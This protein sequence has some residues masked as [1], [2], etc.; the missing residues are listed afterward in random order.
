MSFLDKLKSSIQDNIKIA[1]DNIQNLPDTIKKKINT[2]VSKEN[3]G[4]GFDEAEE[5]VGEVPAEEA[6]EILKIKSINGNVTIKGVKGTKVLKGLGAILITAGDGSTIVSETDGTI[7]IA[8]PSEKPKVVAAAPYTVTVT[9]D[10][11]SV[12]GTGIKPVS[13]K[14]TV[15]IKGNGKGK[16][17]IK[18][19]FIKGV[20][21]IIIITGKDGT[22][23]VKIP[24][25]K[26]PDGKPILTGAISVIG[27]DGNVITT[28]TDG[29]VTTTDPDGIITK[30]GP[31]GTVTATDEYGVTTTTPPS[32]SDQISRSVSVTFDKV[33][34]IAGPWL[35]AIFSIF[36]A[37]T[38]ANDMIIYPR[39][40]RII[41]FIFTIIIINFNSVGA[42]AIP[43]YYIVKALYRQ[44]MNKTYGT[45]HK[46][47]PKF[48]AFL[49][50][51]DYNPEKK[52]FKS[53][54]RGF[55]A[56]PKSDR[57]DTLLSDMTVTYWGELKESFKKFDDVEKE[58]SVEELFKKGTEIAKKSVLYINNRRPII[59]DKDALAKE[60][61][62][63]AAAKDKKFSRESVE[64]CPREDLSLIN[65]AIPKST[66]IA[67][68]I[69]AYPASASPKP[70]AP[71]APSPKPSAPPSPKPSAPP[72]P[73]PEPSAPPLSALSKPPTYPK[74]P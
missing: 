39:V 31:D 56:Y 7:D 16:K 48:F 14:G 2:I 24:D 50:V 71:P 11:I 27:P 44:Y 53:F 41:F 42:T 1:K 59:F 64:S 61:A 74:P 37:V 6:D 60:L 51:I 19:E 26:T 40:I 34:K 69:I 12:S 38:V 30:T 72:A 70:S 45:H 43:S 68:P 55:C 9:G 58:P 20:D 67:S 32:A 33:N 18:G 15:N 49:P 36:M 46:L 66:S 5:P 57:S 28:D 25:G 8:S 21:N 52:G 35:L 47:F 63:K 3:D 13:G 17:N 62:D 54:L 10:T 22:V 73:S 65:S 23:T 4:E 29:T